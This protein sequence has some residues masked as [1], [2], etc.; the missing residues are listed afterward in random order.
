MSIKF[1]DSKKQQWEKVATM[2][3]NS[4]RV[5]D[6]KGNYSSQT[7]EGCLDEIAEGLNSKFDDVELL[8]DGTFNFYSNGKIIKT[9]GVPTTK[10]G[11]IDSEVIDEI[12][13]RLDD[14]EARITW[15]EENGGGGGSTDGN[16]APTITTTFSQTHFSTEDEI[17][18][19]YFV[20]DSQGGNFIANYSIV[21]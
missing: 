21:S 2:L 14:H 18:I 13:K 20:M 4:V 3:A 7:V 9:V 10:N 1:Y 6:I 11:N 19:P 15:L 8:S 12:Y 17:E 5:L 16:T